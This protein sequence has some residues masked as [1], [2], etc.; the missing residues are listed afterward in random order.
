MRS[1]L[2]VLVVALSALTLPTHAA[3]PVAN[4]RLRVG[5][6]NIFCVMAP[7][8]WRGIAKAGRTSGGPADLLWSEQEIP[9][10]DATPEDAARITDAWSADKCLE[11]EGRMTGKTL[12][13]ARIV[14]ECV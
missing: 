1:I 5:K 4:E 2:S 12:R 10:L 13:V 11:I 8:P 7:C 14:G 3:D 6:T 9:Q